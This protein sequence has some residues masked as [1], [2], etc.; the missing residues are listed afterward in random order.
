MDKDAPVIAR[1]IEGRAECIAVFL[2]N[3]GGPCRF[4]SVF[5]PAQSE[6]P[7]HLVVVRACVA[8]CGHRADTG[9]RLPV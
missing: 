9:C 2:Q 4:G 3:M 1:A 6:K 5:A 8:R 7:V